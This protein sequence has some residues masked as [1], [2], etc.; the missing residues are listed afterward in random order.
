MNCDSVSTCQEHLKAE[1]GSQD[2]PKFCPN[3]SLF[4]RWRDCT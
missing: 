4:N 1:S 3:S 2:V